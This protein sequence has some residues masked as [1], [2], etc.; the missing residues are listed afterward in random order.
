MINSRLI[1][2]LRMLSHQAHQDKVWMSQNA[3][4]YDCYPESLEVFYETWDLFNRDS[5]KGQL[6][7]GEFQLL[8]DLHLMIKHFDQSTKGQDPIEILKDPRWESIR[9][10]ALNLL[11]LLEGKKRGA[12]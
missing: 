7:S 10:K 8:R 9:N 3:P 12:R 1:P 2:A 4:G 11:N 5:A 6:T